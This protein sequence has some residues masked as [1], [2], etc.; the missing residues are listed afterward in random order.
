MW[1]SA[2]GPSSAQLGRAASDE[3]KEIPLKRRRV[4]FLPE[5]YVLLRTLLPIK[6]EVC[7]PEGQDRKG[8]FARH[9]VLSATCPSTD[10]VAGNIASAILL[11]EPVKRESST[12]FPGGVYTTACKQK[13]MR[14]NTRQGR[15][16]RK[17]ETERICEAFSG[18]G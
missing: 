6:R 13:R 3:R 4:F 17:Y 5:L 10:A 8:Y 1:S 15:I 18:R 7:W 16:P 11:N 14:E 9:R 12:G 2:F